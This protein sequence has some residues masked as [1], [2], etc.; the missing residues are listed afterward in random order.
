MA[1]VNPPA[2]SGKAVFRDGYCSSSSKSGYLWHPLDL[3]VQSGILSARGHAL[4]FIDAVADGLDGDRLIERLARARPE[5]ILGLAGDVSWPADVRF[6]RRLAA[7]LPTTRLVLSGDV[8]R[9]ESMKAFRELPSLD[10][11]LTDFSQSGFADWVDGERSAV[12]GLLLRDASPE[13]HEAA[14]PPNRRPWSSSPARHDLLGRRYRLP[15]HGGLPFASVLASYGC[16]YSCTFCNTG[17]LG[18]RG[19]DTGEVISELQGVRRLGYRRVYLRDA[20]ANGKRA[21][22]LELCRAWERADLG[23]SWN[24]FCTFSPFDA[25]LAGAMAGAGCRVVQFGIEAGDDAIRSANGKAFRNDAAA[26]AVRYAH[27]AGMQVCGHFV[28][29]LPGQDE[30][31]VRRTLAFAREL[32][33]DFASFNLAAARPGTALRREADERGMPG[34]DASG[35]GFIAGLS[36]IEPGR[37]RALKRTGTL[38]FYLRP[39]PLRAVLPDLRH[40]EGWAHLAAMGRAFVRTW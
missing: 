13:S 16:P 17:E 26:A 38:N 34:G 5:V 4:T 23:L 3:L 12:A 39:R 9:F 37:L 10:A 6:Y 19:R 30:D 40:R 32:D 21:A 2:L 27:D 36:A 7:R 31:G 18:Y 28:L 11:V 24:V 33:L 25:E 29:G 22:L 20:T 1:L 35:D 14:T 8:P 15:F